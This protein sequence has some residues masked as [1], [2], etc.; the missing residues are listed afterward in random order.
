VNEIVVDRDEPVLAG[1]ADGDDAGV[2]QDLQMMGDGR[3]RQ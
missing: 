1:F 2:G 3:L